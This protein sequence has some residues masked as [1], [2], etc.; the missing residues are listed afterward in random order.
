MKNKSITPLRKSKI[1]RLPF[2]I[3]EQLNRR[4]RDSEAGDSVL[5]WLN[6][7]PEVKATLDAEFAGRP[8]T[9][10]NLSEWRRTGHCDWLVRQDALEI[11]GSLNDE[12]ELGDSSLTGPFAE[13]LARWT[14]LQ[15]AS[16]ARALP[17]ETDPALKWQLLHQLSTDIAR[18]RRAELYADHLGLQRGWLALDQENARQKSDDEFWAW[19]KR[20]DIQRKL[21]PP[22]QRGLTPEGRLRLEEDLCLIEEPGPGVARAMRHYRLFQELISRTESTD[23]E[24]I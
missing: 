18:L 15:Y 7:L 20:P 16:L 1:A 3:R 24:G 14:A 10:Q 23:G 22:A 4:L 8:I 19:T 6:G 17:A 11:A 9:K 21:N 2:E 5:K 13:K 12:Q